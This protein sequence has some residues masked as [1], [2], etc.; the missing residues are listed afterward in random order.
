MTEKMTEVS[1]DLSAYL[2]E[3]REAVDAA[4]DR[5]L[6]APGTPPTRLSEAMRYSVFSGGKRLRPILAIAGFELAGGR[7]GAV[8]APACAAEMIHAYSLIHDDLPAMDD[9]DVRRGRPT[10]HR[11]FDEATAVLA[12]DALLTLAF[13][14]VAREPALAPHTRLAIIEELARA[15]GAAGMVGGQAA[16]VDSEGQAATVESVEFIHERKTAEPLRAAVVVGGLAAGAG[17]AAL[18]S[19]A[20]YGR[21]V[22]LA[23]QI[24]DDVLDV[25]GSE[26]VVGK[27][28]G[29]DE[30]AGK[31]TYPGAVGVEAARSRAAELANEAVLSLAAFGDEAWALREIARFVVDRRS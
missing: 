24:A 26:K 1:R 25:T 20:S 2:A 27:A 31:L 28:V 10:C 7:G 6:P 18:A 14:V 11:A 4:L 5:F 16:D 8:F 17:G 21:A 23:F 9:D 3:R 29:K 15:N 12:G 22:G 13:G 30:A 19:L